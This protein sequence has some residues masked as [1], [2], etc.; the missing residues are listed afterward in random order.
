MDIKYVGK[1][2]NTFGYF[3]LIVDGELVIG[4][5]YKSGAKRAVAIHGMKLADDESSELYFRFNGDGCIHVD[6]IERNIRVLKAAFSH[7]FLNDP[8][9]K[10]TLNSALK[11]FADEHC[12]TILHGLNQAQGIPK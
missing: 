10:N 2:G 4:D 1:T 12:E 8:L 5:Y 9:S 11:K 3:V 6:H 7:L